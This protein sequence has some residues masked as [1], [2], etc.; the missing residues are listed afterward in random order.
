MIEI[1]ELTIVFQNGHYKI[2]ALTE[3]DLITKVHEYVRVIVSGIVWKDYV[4]EG[5]YGYEIIEADTP[6]HIADKIVF[7]VK[8]TIAELRDNHLP[9]MKEVMEELQTK[10]LVLEK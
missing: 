10:G 4:V 2:E 9:L 8:N 5:E 3:Y 1:K 7:K 6:D